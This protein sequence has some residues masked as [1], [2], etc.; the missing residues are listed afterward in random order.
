[1][2]KMIITGHKEG[3]GKGITDAFSIMCNVVG[4]DLSEGKNVN[5]PAV[6]DEFVEDCADAEVIILNAHTGEQHLLLAELYATYKD[7]DKLCIVLGSMV[8]QMYDEQEQVPNEWN[9]GKYWDDKCKLDKQ[10]KKIQQAGQQPFRVT[11][12]RPGWV[13]TRL[14][15]EWKGKTL[16]VEAVVNVVRHIIIHRAVWHI[17]TFEVQVRE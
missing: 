11:I 15:T 5:D 10:V 1:M 12:V 14:A 16:P 6:W 3:I 2:S 8:T 7:Q 17:P 4:Y 13:D 9:F